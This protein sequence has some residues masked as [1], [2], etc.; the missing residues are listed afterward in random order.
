MTRGLVMRPSLSLVLAVLLGGAAC[1]G[2]EAPSPYG[3]AAR[4]WP[5]EI[6]VE[7]VPAQDAW[8]VGYVLPAEVAGVEFSA[9]GEPYRAA[10]WGVGL[11]EGEATWY[12]A[13]GRERLCFSRPARA[14][15]AGFLSWEGP[16]GD[17]PVTVT[18]ENGGR[19][20]STGH[21]RVRPLSR[22]DAEGADP[23]PVEPEHR[24]TFATAEGRIVRIAGEAGTLEL[25]GAAAGAGAASLYVG[26]GDLG[27][28]PA[29][30]ESDS[31]TLLLDPDLPGWFRDQTAAD[32]PRLLER[33][34]A[35]TGVPLPVRPLVAV[36]W[37]GA[38][39]PAGATDRA[40]SGT[41]LPGVLL[42][43]AEGAGWLEPDEAARRDGFRAL[44]RQTL[45][46]WARGH[47]PVDAESAWL[48][49]AA[50]DRF[51]LDAALAFGIES[52]QEAARRPIERAN[53]CLVRLG[54]R[55]LREAAE[56]GNRTARSCGAV[57]LDVAAGALRRAEPPADLGLLFRRLFEHAAATGAY[58][59]APFVAGLRELG[60]DPEAI[61]DLRRLIVARREVQTERFLQRLLGH[62]GV[63]T[64]PVPPAEAVATPEAVAEAVRRA[65]GR[66]WCGAEAP[67]DPAD[68]GR[69]CDPVATGE[70]VTAVAGTPLADDP[71]AA[72][73][74]LEAAARGAALTVTLDDLETTLFCG[75][76][77]FDSTWDALLAPA[78]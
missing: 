50:A 70:G 78:P 29:A 14:F 10:R 43:T 37:G 26:F 17:R 2:V 40:V 41:V 77:L 16:P 48:A 61:D 6:S 13:G 68:A 55:S 34:A 58:G 1:T 8:R 38:E 20:L 18:L 3:G 52:E 62:A 7:E 53:D 30:V 45:L 59:A 60:A 67:S 54:G 21:L 23:L 36:A 25:R 66:C 12:A 63:E 71:S 5:I 51:A 31:A 72:W 57:A 69:A 11:G 15:S 44:A 28:E 74:H 32:L 24:F 65:V 22:C 75:P 64:V 35:V 39:T 49:E 56:A 4:S 33:F 76:E 9:G 19:L 27:G 42:V 46:L 47:F 73:H